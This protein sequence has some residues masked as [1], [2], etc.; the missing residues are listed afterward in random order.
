M[1]TKNPEKQ[2]HWGWG[3]GGGGVTC[4]WGR[5]V[6]GAP[7]MLPGAPNDILPNL[8]QHFHYKNTKCV[9]KF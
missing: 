1:Q 7:G 4:G 9:Y 2:E 5:G 6:G 3:G 8:Y